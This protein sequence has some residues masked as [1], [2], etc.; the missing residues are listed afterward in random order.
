MRY[1]AVLPTLL[2]LAIQAL[3][4]GAMAS[5]RQFTYTHE[6]NVLAPGQKELELW[7]T[8]RQGREDFYKRLDNRLEFEIGVA[9][10]IMTAVYLNQTRI[11]TEP[12]PGVTEHEVE[13]SMSW[14]WKFKLSDAAAD[15]AGQALYVEG[16]I[17]S[18]EAALEAK[19]ILDKVVGAN[20]FAANLVVEPEWDLTPAS[21]G[22]PEIEVELTAGWSYRIG[23]G[24]A[25][26]LELRQ[27]N[28]IEYE[29]NETESEWEHEHA[30]LFGGPVVHGANSHGW[31]TLT[32]MPQLAAF[33]QV[34]GSSS[35][36]D[37]EAYE[38][39][40]V[41]LIIGTDF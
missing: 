8:W 38:R 4:A 3:P 18:D 28:E 15:A 19:Y 16:T 30:V 17:A 12:A 20:L 36:L 5:E 37:L 21:S 33:K 14:E 31:A 10:S 24:W 27:A 40:N 2:A 13:T 35:S 23:S 7:G 26:G 9:P 32:V 11:T 41:R 39:V 22:K 6:S 29:D 25:A 34:K 1:A